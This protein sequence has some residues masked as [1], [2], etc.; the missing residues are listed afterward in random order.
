MRTI[1]FGVACHVF[2]CTV[3]MCAQSQAPNPA[4]PATSAAS[5]QPRPAHDET[6]DWPNL[7]RYREENAKLSPPAPGENRV[8]FMG[9]SITDAWGRGT[10]EFFPG[11]PY[12]NRG[13]SGQTT[14]QMLVRFRPD[15]IALQPKVVVILAGTNDI[16]G[17]TGPSTPRIIEDNFMSMADLAKA[18]GI[19]VVLASILPAADYPWRPGLQP[20]GKIRELNLWIKSYCGEK[21][22][23]YLDYYSAMVDQ[24]GGLPK[25]LSQDGVHPNKRGYDIMGPLAEKAI[26]A[27]LAQ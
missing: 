16:A 10:G 17:N 7:A 14:P 3:L 8:V 1:L 27:A 25:T 12:I 13:I 9:D 21:G 26:A 2:I 22:Y 20:A 6:Q 23:T 5:A 15:V 11:K 18:N 24:A 19:R 4:A